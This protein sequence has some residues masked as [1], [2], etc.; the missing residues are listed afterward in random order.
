MLPNWGSEFAK[1]APSMK[2]L[3]YDGLPEERRQLRTDVV[4]RGDFH[5][6][7]THYDLVMRDK[8]FLRKVGLLH[9]LVHA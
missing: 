8:A 1:W 6:M 9:T 7:V 4:D 2:C 3:V 5:V